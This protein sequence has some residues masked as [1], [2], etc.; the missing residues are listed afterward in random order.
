MTTPAV[1]SSYNPVLTRAVL[2]ALVVHGIILLGITFR[3]PEPVKKVQNALDITLASYEDKQ[4][5]EKADFVAQSNQSGSGEAEKKLRLTTTERADFTDKHINDL[6]AKQPEPS[7]EEQAP[8][9]Q[10]VEAPPAPAQPTPEVAPAPPP[11]PKVVTTHSKK[12]VAVKQ[13][14]VH[15]KAPAAAPKAAKSDGPSLTARSLEIASM[16]AS[17]DM[18]RQEYAK[19]PRVR[20]LNSNSTERSE[21]AF[22]LNAWKDKIQQVGN[23]NYPEAS[24]KQGIY[25]RLRL[26]VILRPDGSVKDIQVLQ[27]SGYQVLDDAAKKIV[28]LASPFAP[29][30]PKMRAEVDQLEIIRTWAFEKNR[31]LF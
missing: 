13:E 23:M 30:P 14:P 25:G 1:R 16:E 3:F 31:T 5:P 29:F 2:I 15:K 19:R 12:P 27:S 21:D 26:L 17:L 20:T 10:Q 9:V 7:T 11:K 8:P 24:R 18:M 6:A 4:K 28:R 22:Y